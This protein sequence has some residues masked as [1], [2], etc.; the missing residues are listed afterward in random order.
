MKLR[1]K[2]IAAAVV[3]AALTGIGLVGCSSSGGGGS[4]TYTFWDPYAGYTASSPWAKLIDKCGTEAGVK[5]KRTTFD[6]TDLTNK[7]LLAGQQGTAPNV[8]IIDNPVVST[9][10]SSGMLTTTATNGLST[11]ADIKG[12]LDAGI[13]NGKTYGVPVGANTL[14]LYYNKDVLSAAGIDPASI[15]DWDSLNAAL[16][17]LKSAGKGGITFSAVGTEEGS[18]QFL[19]W[20]WGAGANLRDLDSAGAV[21]ALTQW[22]D[23]LKEGYAPNSALT[24]VQTVA[25]NQFA[26]GTYGFAEEGPW[27]M[28]PAKS[29]NFKYGIIPIP[30]QK[31]GTPAQTPTGGEF[32]TIPV[33]KDTS[34]YK[35]STKIVDCLTATKNIVGTNETLNYVPPTK[36]AQAAF[37]KAQPDFQT[38]VDAVNNAKSRTGDNLGTKYPKISQPMWTAIQNAL[39]GSQSPSAALQQAQAAAAKA[40]K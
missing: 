1:Y 5:I 35:T 19:P 6:T 31:G 39:S 2:K 36:A 15:K 33:Q 18:F 34:T 25:W 24:N 14:Q 16:A 32:L 20:F 17:K 10:A 13:I 27:E 22:T 7:A 21:A 28:G 23:W 37:V 12:I 30:S 38:W 26:T 29:L 9:L 40:T 4:K 8:L 11:S 3:V